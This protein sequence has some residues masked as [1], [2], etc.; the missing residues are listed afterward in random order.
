MTLQGNRGQDTPDSPECFQTK[1]R[2]LKEKGNLAL[3]TIWLKPLSL[4]SLIYL[5]LVV[6]KTSCRLTNSD[7]DMLSK[8]VD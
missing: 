1:S 3:F 6:M 2:M 8:Q 5:P 7:V 4:S